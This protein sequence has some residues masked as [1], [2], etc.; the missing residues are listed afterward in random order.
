MTNPTSAALAALGFFF[1]GHETRPSGAV[2]PTCDGPPDRSERP[3]WEE[4]KAAW[5]TLREIER[6]RADGLVKM[7]A[8][9]E[10]FAKTQPVFT[11]TFEVDVPRPIERR[12]V[13]YPC[14]GCGALSGSTLCEGWYRCKRCGYPGK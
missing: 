8:A 13:D 12:G 11:E 4:A 14:E 7:H 3:I 2:C 6:A 5:L 9:L 10:A 1:C